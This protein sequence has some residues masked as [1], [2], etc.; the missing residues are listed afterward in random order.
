MK[1]LAVIT[2]TLFLALFGSS[3]IQ[4]K[5]IEQTI[6]MVNIN[7]A[8]VET[9]S[10]LKGV[11]EKKAQAIVEWR[12][13]NGGFKQVSQIVSVKGIGDS[14]LEANKKYLVLK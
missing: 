6:P 9:L 12:D 10:L 7:T 13:K 11:G 3:L 14:I 5:D 1:K 4:A 2:F 8:S